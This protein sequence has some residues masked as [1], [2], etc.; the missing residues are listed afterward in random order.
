MPE[1]NEVL[2][3]LTQAIIDGD[4]DQ[5]RA[6]AEQGAAAGFDPLA[7]VEKGLRPGMDVIGERFGS[8]D[9]FL[10]E[11]VMAAESMKAALTVI[12]PLLRASQQQK[13]VAGKVVLATVLGDIHEIGKT[14]VGTML[15]A[16]GFEVTDLGV[17]VPVEKIV[18]AVGETQAD[19]VG[20]SALLTTTMQ[21]QRRVI[22]ALDAQGLRAACKVIV[23]GAPTNA[24]W[25]R[26]IEA[27][28]YGENAADAVRVARALMNKQEVL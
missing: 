27:D 2:S 22:E 11:L 13:N 15:T 4:P 23:G 28:G 20:L 5:A 6:L 1:L 12:D 10:P 21:Q 24:D 19:I 9:C 16:S 8:G 26:Q 3:G 18:Q 25:A 7:M 17:N 14:L